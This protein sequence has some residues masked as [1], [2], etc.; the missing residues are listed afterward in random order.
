MARF[1]ALLR[2][3]N[4]GGKHKLPMAE[5]RAAFEDA[6]AQAVQSYIQSGNVVFEATARAAPTVA[7]SVADW[8]EATKGF[9]SP[10]VLRSAKAWQRTL[11]ENPFADE[12]EAD[13]KRVHVV[14]LDR[15][16]TPAAR[17][18]FAPDCRLDERWELTKDALYV[19]YAGGTARSKL[20]VAYI[21]RVLGC[22]ATGR[23]WR[24]ALALHDLLQA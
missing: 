7:T 15:A 17:A 8:I 5:L 20:T 24:T 21:D 6:G 23:N 18:A 11:A 2:G 9:A 22:V 4:V 19:H 10:I 16:P 12:A 13:P 1:A 3:I 14:L